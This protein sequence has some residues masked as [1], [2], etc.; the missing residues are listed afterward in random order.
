LAKILI[1]LAFKGFHWLL[2][3]VKRKESLK[4]G[5]KGPLEVPG[6]HEL[7]CPHHPQLE[8]LTQSAGAVE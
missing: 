4:H 1:V 8:L 5:A 2:G 3:L 7:L 6:I